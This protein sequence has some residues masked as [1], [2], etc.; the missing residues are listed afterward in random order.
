MEDIIIYLL[1]SALFFLGIVALVAILAIP[2]VRLFENS[3]AKII[4]GQKYV[5]G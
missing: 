1:T 4:Q 3:D 2:F 5:N